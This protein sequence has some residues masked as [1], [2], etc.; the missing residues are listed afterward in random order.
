M[1]RDIRKRV[2]SRCIFIVM[3][4]NWSSRYATMAKGSKYA[5]K[6]TALPGIS[7]SKACVK[8]LRSYEEPWTPLLIRMAESRFTCEFHGEKTPQRG[9]KF[10]QCRKAPKFGF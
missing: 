10:T 4:L 7:A 1:W 9:H 2:K 5:T 6:M 8:E 3:R